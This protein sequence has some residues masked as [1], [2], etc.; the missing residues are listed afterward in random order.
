LA[1]GLN[2]Q[3]FS[4]SYFALFHIFRLNRFPPASQIPGCIAFPKG[5][6]NFQLALWDFVF[7]PVLI[8]SRGGFK[9]ASTK[10]SLNMGQ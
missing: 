6:G 8:I 10:L 5:V 7:A 9:P 2:G 1:D 4:F 3:P